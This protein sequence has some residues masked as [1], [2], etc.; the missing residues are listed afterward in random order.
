MNSAEGLSSIRTWV[1]SAWWPEQRDLVDALAAKSHSVAYNEHVTLCGSVGFLR[2]GVGSPRAATALTHLLSVSK[3]HGS[4]PD[5]VFFLA[6]AGAY[7]SQHALESAHFVSAVSWCD[8]D[9]LRG[10]SYLPGLKSG[11]E[12]LQA[13]LEPFSSATLS[14]LSTPGIT[15]APELSRVLAGQ[16]DFENLELYG[17]ALAAEDFGVPWGAV[18]GVSNVVGPE[19]HPQWREHHLKASH[20]A[21]ELLYKHCLEKIL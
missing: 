8:G 14:A 3:F 21:Q 11:Y 2:T 1:V 12:R 4:Q 9:L 15:L 5:A 18:L 20:A 10:D 16:G 17:V 6:T 7:A 13:G 19:A